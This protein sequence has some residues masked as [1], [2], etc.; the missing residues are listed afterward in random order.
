MSRKLL[1]IVS[2]GLLALC[3]CRTPK[4]KLER[5]VK[6]HPELLR[7]TT[8]IDYDTTIIDIPAVH[9]DS[10]IHINT[11]KTDTF[12]MEKEHLRVQTIY[13]NDSVFIT[14]DCFGIKDTIVSVEEI[15]TKYIVNE[16]KEINWWKW[17]VL[18]AFVY[19]VYKEYLFW[20]KSKA[21]VQ[22]N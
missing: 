9:S 21:N 22:E 3:S 12:I 19:L 11:L 6:K 10:I 2:M 13:R 17:L 16:P 8:I 20:K 15:K 7:D 5:L 1:L 18:A 14:G 4:E